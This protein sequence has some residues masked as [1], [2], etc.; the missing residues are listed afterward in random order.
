MCIEWKRVFLKCKM[1]SL[2]QLGCYFVCSRDECFEEDF[3]E[4]GFRIVHWL[5]WSRWMHLLRF[6]HVNFLARAR[7][8]IFA[9]SMLLKL[10]PTH[11]LL[12]SFQTSHKFRFLRLSLSLLIF[13]KH[14][15][16]IWWWIQNDNLCFICEMCI[17]WR[18]KNH[19]SYTC[20]WC[21]LLE[22]GDYARR[23][24]EN[25]IRCCCCEHCSLFRG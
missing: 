8:S 24:Y 2:H 4:K 1:C 19:S 18:E 5:I 7:I 20:E 15:W 13:K 21:L 10:H 17:S 22:M 25:Q 3:L 23:E 11:M 12:K 9:H 14:V 16:S 6:E